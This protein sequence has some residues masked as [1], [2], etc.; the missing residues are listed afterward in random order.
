MK[1]LSKTALRLLAALAICASVSA[2]SQSALAPAAATGFP[3]YAAQA[4][5]A[6]QFVAPSIMD[7]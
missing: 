4:P 1:N 5:S 6:G 3:T 7:Y 2:C